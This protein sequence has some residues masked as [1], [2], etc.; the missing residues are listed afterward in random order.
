MFR[1]TGKPT[2]SPRPVE[3]QFQKPEEDRIVKF[4]RPLRMDYTIASICHF[5][6][7]WNRPTFR[8]PCGHFD[9]LSLQTIHFGT[10]KIHSPF[11]NWRLYS[12]I[13]WLVM[14]LV[15]SKPLCFTGGATQQWRGW[16]QHSK[17]SCR[18]SETTWGQGSYWRGIPAL[19]TCIT[20]N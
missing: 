8:A 6:P 4:C 16:E 5:H 7:K 12:E 10:C 13:G 14:D 3:V 19:T 11:L 2:S 18:P 15:S 20:C 17:C 1:R 9:H